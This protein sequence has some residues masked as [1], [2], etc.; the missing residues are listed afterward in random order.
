LSFVTDH[1]HQYIYV[2][3][4]WSSTSSFFPVTLKIIIRNVTSRKNNDVQLQNSNLKFGIM[5]I[6]YILS[7]FREK[8]HI[9]GQE[10]TEQVYKIW[11]KNLQELLSNHIFGVGHF[12]KAA[13]CSTQKLWKSYVHA[14]SATALNRRS[15]YVYSQNNTTVG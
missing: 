9:N 7:N 10:P 4:L 6:S 11:R 1:T 5:S 15:R 3:V 14:E 2:S 13:P 8:Q 12:F